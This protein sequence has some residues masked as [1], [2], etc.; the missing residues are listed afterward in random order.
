MAHWKENLSDDDY[1]ADRT[2]VGSTDLRLV[3][4]SPRAFH[5]RFLRYGTPKESNALRIGKIIHL[6]V[7]EGPRFKERYVVM[8]QFVGRTLKGELS[9]NC[10]EA[11]I[12]RQEWL[13]AQPAD[14]LIVTAEERD[15]FV[16]QIES[17]LNHPQGKDLIKDSHIEIAG[18]H[19]DPETGIRIKVKLDILGRDF[20]KVVD[21]KSA[22]HSGFF[23]FG[24]AAFRHRYDIQVFTYAEAVRSITGRF[25]EV[26]ALLVVEK[27]EP[28]ESAIYYYDREDLVQA[29]VD[30]HTAL[31]RLRECIDK[32]AWPQ[33]QSV[34]ERIHTP[35]WFINKSMQGEI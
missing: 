25:P 30:Y 34:I 29:E 6:A 2:A 14:T 13:N 3:L 11:R 21:L 33:R 24:S 17:I 26:I 18:Y 27:E 19:R 8:P 28:Y 1:H 9:S 16:G 10:K 5:R 23:E 4:D 22:A 35:M 32:D 20:V 7:L 31:R 15:M 12:K